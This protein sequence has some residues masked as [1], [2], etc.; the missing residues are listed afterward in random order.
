MPGAPAWLVSIDQSLGAM[1]GS[2]NGQFLS[3][4]G[5][6]IES[7]MSGSPILNADGAAIGLISTSSED[8]DMGNMHPEHH[9]TSPTMA[10]DA[11]SDGTARGMT[12]KEF[13]DE[14]WAALRAVRDDWPE[15]V[16]WSEF[17]RKL[18]GQGRMYWSQHEGRKQF[19]LPPKMRKRLEG[20]L[21]QSRKL[22][23][24]LSSLPR[25]V[26]Y[27]APDFGFNAV[28]EWLQNWLFIYKSLEGPDAFGFSGRSDYYRDMLCKWLVVEWGDTLGGELSFARD[29]YEVPYGPLI[30]FLSIT[31]TAILGKAPGPSGLAK[32]IDQYR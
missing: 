28:E 27:G 20:L 11:N 31:L 5:V 15:G 22:Q 26:L 6:K 7:G 9:G 13:T 3:L 8:D 10:V 32:I 1:H 25:H 24:D 4:R 16:D 23:G 19:G 18:D 21:R 12:F 14:Q 30:D 2:H 17:R 29:Q